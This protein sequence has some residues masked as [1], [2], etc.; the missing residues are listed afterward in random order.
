MPNAKNPSGIGLPY[1]RT[2]TR[3]WGWTPLATDAD[4]T[5][6]CTATGAAL[7]RFDAHAP[8]S[9]EAPRHVRAAVE[10]SL[11]GDVLA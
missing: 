1:G 9:S 11:G 8:R 2:K 4:A 6:S 5:R 7:I 10:H 3:T